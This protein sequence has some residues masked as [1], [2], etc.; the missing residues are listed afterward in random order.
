MVVLASFSSYASFFGGDGGFTGGSD[1]ASFVTYIILVSGFISFSFF[2]SLYFMQQQAI[3]QLR[4]KI[5]S[6]IASKPIPASSNQ[7]GQEKH[8]LMNSSK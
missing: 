5:T 3:Q 8:L 6:K 1:S 4:I 2:F 7:T